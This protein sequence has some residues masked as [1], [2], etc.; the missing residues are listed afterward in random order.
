MAALNVSERDFRNPKAITAG[1]FVR[2]P[3]HETCVRYIIYGAGAIGSILGGHLHRIGAQVVLVGPPEHVRAI[4]KA[5]LKLR[6]RDKTFQLRVPAVTRAADLAPFRK[7]DVVLLCAKTQQT[8]KCLSQLRAAGAPRSLPVFCCQNSFLNEPQTTLYFERVYGMAVFIDGIFVKPG[9][10][11]HPTGRR[12]GHLEIGR[13]PTGLDAFSRQLT[14]DLRSAGFSVR[15]TPDVMSVKRAKFVVNMANAVIGITN[16]PKQALPLVN[17]LRAE[18]VR[19]LK[20]SGLSCESLESFRRR[21]LAR[22]GELESPKDADVAGLIADSTW[23]SLYRRTG[24]I[25]TPYFN[26]VVVQMGQSLGIPTPYNSFVLDI[27]ISMAKR[28]D[29]PG[30]YSVFELLRMFRARRV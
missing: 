23:Q 17:R 2:L 13:Y 9:E 29:R 24:N 3:A 22:C 30:K 25:E 20:A 21:A 5:G 26:G 10:A 6:T 18:A 11:I 8:L 14:R 27:A 4:K 12:Y 7:G 19:V 28:G 16:Q 1:D 15:A